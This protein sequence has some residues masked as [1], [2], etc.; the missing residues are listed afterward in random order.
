[1]ARLKASG[2]RGFL[3]GIPELWAVVLDRMAGDESIG[4]IRTA[5]RCELAARLDDPSPAG[6]YR[7]FLSDCHRTEFQPGAGPPSFQAARRGIDRECHSP[8]ICFAWSATARWASCWPLTGSPPSLESGRVSMSL[9]RQL[10][11][12]LIQEA[13]RRIAGN[14]R[15]LQHLSDWLTGDDRRGSSHGRE[16]APRR[17][18]RLA[19]RTGLSAPAAVVPISIVRRVVGIEP[20]GGRPRI[21]R[22]EK[23]DLS[24]AN[25]ERACA[26]QTRFHRANLH[27]ALLTWVPKGPT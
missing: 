10:P 19:A 6:T 27:G 22:P 9:A 4:D 8:W 17:D 3:K 23:A 24:E 2:D 7:G 11:R 25:L 18:A 13:A 21:R 5:L 15:S 12:E 1:M 16:P 20:R 14:T 26:N